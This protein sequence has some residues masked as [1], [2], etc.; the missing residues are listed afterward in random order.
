M[1]ASQRIFALFF[2]GF[3]AVALIAVWYGILSEARKFDFWEMMVPVVL[4][5][6]G[7][8]FTIR[9]FRNSILLS[10][11][12]IELRSLV[13]NNILPFDNIKGRRRYLDKGAAD[14][15]SVGHLV[16]ESN[17][18]RFPKIDIQVTYKFDDFFYRWFHSLPDLDELDKTRS[19]P[20]N[21]GLV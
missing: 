13:G 11:A 17:D 10:E 15:P 7:V 3:S 1:N 21:F 9:T 6:G 5:I 4:L 12:S 16:L 2:S 14:G 20:S 19:K 18:Y 8:L